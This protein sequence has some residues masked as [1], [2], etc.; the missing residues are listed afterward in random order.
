M[1]KAVKELFIKEYKRM[2]SDIY[3]AGGN[4]WRAY[5]KVFKGGIVKFDNS[6]YQ[7][8]S[9]LPYVGEYFFVTFD[10]SSPFASGPV[11]VTTGSFD[12]R[13]AICIIDKPL[14]ELK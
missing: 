3:G 13:D 9:L 8:D 10:G 14:T 6:R 4:L 11:F 2:Y 12:C 5:R 7:H 1:K